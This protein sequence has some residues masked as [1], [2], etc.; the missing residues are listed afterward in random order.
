MLNYLLVGFGGF[1]G[2]AARYAVGQ[3][4]HSF[5]S[6]PFPFHTLLVNFF[7][8]LGAGFL[9]EYLRDHPFFTTV[10]LTVVTGFLGAFTTFSAFGFESILLIRANSNVLALLNIA[11]NLLLCLL[12]IIIG[13]WIGSTFET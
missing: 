4:V 8:C 9:Y 13:T 11:G 12:A 5:T 7:G 6:H 1:F 3:A 2:A 10:S